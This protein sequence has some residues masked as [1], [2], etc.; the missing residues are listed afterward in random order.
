MVLKSRKDDEELMRL[1]AELEE[2]FPEFKASTGTTQAIDIIGG[3]V[4]S[5]VLPEEVFAIINHRIADSR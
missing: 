2:R 3:G 1:S 4:K 5:N